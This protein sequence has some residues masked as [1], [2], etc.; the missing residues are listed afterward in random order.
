M[1]QEISP[2][3]KEH[4]DSQQHTQIQPAR[5]SYATTRQ[6]PARKPPQGGLPTKLQ[7]DNTGYRVGPATACKFKHMHP[8]ADQSQSQ[9]PQQMIERRCVGS[10]WRSLVGEKAKAWG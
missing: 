7:A 5:S 4:P 3:G 9:L 8:H 1:E 10:S 2:S 6:K